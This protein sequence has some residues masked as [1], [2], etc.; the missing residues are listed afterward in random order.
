MEKKWG[1]SI[2]KWNLLPNGQYHMRVAIWDDVASKNQDEVPDQWNDFYGYISIPTQNVVRWRRRVVNGVKELQR[3]DTLEWIPASELKELYPQVQPATDTYT[4][5]E[6]VEKQIKD[7]IGSYVKRWR[8]SGK[9]QISGMDSR[10]N[11]FPD[12]KNNLSNLLT[13]ISEVDA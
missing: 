1:S 8:V 11:N 10:F 13:R 4:P 9:K 6:W 7:I 2:I 3:A 12:R 5:Q